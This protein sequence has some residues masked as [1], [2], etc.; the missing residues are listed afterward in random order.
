MGSGFVFMEMKME[1]KKKVPATKF[2]LQWVLC[3]RAA[4]FFWATRQLWRSAQSSENPTKQ[5]VGQGIGQPLEDSL[6]H[7]CRAF[8]C[9]PSQRWMWWGVMRFAL[10]AELVPLLSVFCWSK[11]V[12][13]AE[14]WPSPYYRS[15]MRLVWALGKNFVK[16][17]MLDNTVS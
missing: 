4:V 8:S 15:Q 13:L 10:E 3:E 17:K 5:R 14:P 16:L 11:S 1:R 9:P 12:S 6:G 2:V 7:Q